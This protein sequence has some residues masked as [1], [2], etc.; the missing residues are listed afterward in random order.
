M[1]ALLVWKGMKSVGRLSRQ[2]W[3]VIRGRRGATVIREQAE[4]GVTET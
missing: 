2:G 1:L 4:H 3:A